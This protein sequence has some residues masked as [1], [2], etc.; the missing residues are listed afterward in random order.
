MT[1]ELGANHEDLRALVDSMP[2]LCWMAHADGD[3]FFYNRGWFEYTGTQPAEMVNEG[4]RAVHDPAYLPEVVKRWAASV[5][6]GE[7]FSMEFPLRRA[8][9][10]F[11]W[12][13]TR[14]NPLRDEGGKVVRWFGTNTDIDELKR[15]REALDEES[16]LLEI[17]NQ[18]G[19]SIASELDLEKL[20][21]AVT[22]ASTKLTGAAFGAFFYYNTDE[23]GEE[24]VLY[25][26]SGAPREAFSSFPNPRSTALFGPTFRGERT[27]R[28]DNVCTEPVYGQSAPYHGMP[29]GHLPVCSYLAVPVVSRSGQSIGGIFLGHP[30]PGV[31]TARHERIVE[32]VAGQAANAIDN[33]RL[34]DGEKRAAQQ[35]QQG[36]EAERSARAEV[37]RLSLMKD[38]FLATLSHELRTPLNAIMGWA[39]VLRGLGLEE[40]DLVR[41]LEVIERNAKVQAQLIA[42]L[43]DMSSILSGKLRLEVEQTDLSWVIQAAVESV[44]PSAEAKGIRLETIL[45][46]TEGTVSGDPGRLQQVLW[47]LLTNSIKFTPK[48]GKVQVVVERIN[49]HV[50]ISVADTG[51]GITPEFLP[52]VFERFRQA[53]SSTTRRFGGLGLGLSIVK[54]LVELH[55]GTIRA[56]SAGEGQGTTFV[57]C[58]PLSAVRKNSEGLPAP[59]ADTHWDYRLTDLK[60]VTVLVVDDEPD[61]RDLVGR[62]LSECHARVLLAANAEETLRLVEQ[63]R[64]DVLVSDI[65]MPDVDGYELL[66]RVRALGEEKGGRVDA[67]ALTAFAR[68]EDRMRAL[69]AGFLVHTAK[70]VDPSELV[71]TVASVCGRASAF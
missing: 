10:Q 51:I 9:G 34:Y 41:G 40:P 35:R 53:D 43:L 1:L 28:Y 70:P 62:V 31:F 18:T 4:W 29:P 6:S 71:A 52:N 27:I 30:E 19:S 14:V 65:G 46:P 15:T 38:E 49:S 63:E 13:L 36:L 55:G 3:I 16:R 54:K 37:E 42:D 44:R 25:N 45:T 50:E 68:L 32:G 56:L 5:L 61:A 57:V 64:P 58:L 22:D 7:P 26:L 2:Q 39:Q 11:R 20:V 47:N 60:G 48:G 8:D 67:I 59:V 21:Q 33:A 69:R 17:L 23:N 24:L 12:F 66:R